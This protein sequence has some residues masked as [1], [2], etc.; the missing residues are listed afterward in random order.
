MCALAMM[1]SPA[2][3][4]TTMPSPGRQHEHKHA[5]RRAHTSIFHML[6]CVLC[7][8]PKHKVAQCAR[9][10][11]CVRKGDHSTARRSTPLTHAPWWL[12]PSRSAYRTNRWPLASRSSVSTTG[13][14]SGAKVDSVVAS[15]A[16]PAGLVERAQGGLLQQLSAT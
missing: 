4:P 3:C 10:C 5:H 16:S 9:L 15:T 11:A 14:Q 6:L 8:L 1:G 7:A 13:W 2:P 12:L